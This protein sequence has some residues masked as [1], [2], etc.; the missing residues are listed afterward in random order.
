MIN[1]K[2]FLLLPIV[3]LLAASVKLY[4]QDKIKT[5]TFTFVFEGK[6]LSGLVD[7]PVAKAPTALIILVSGS[8]K[9]N[10][11]AG[12]G[13]YSLRKLFIQQGLACLI[14][15]KAGCGKSEGVFDNNQS[16]QNSA[17]EVLS[18]I[19]ESNNRN[20]PGSGNIGLWGIS[21]AGWICPLVIAQ[22]PSIAFWISVSGTDDKESFGYLLE[23]NLLIEGRSEAQTK[24]LV[25]EWKHGINVSKN[26]GTFE[27]NLKATQNLR[28]DPFY[29]FLNGPN[30]P[31]EEGYL[32]WQK[33][34]QT[35]E[36]VMDEQSGLLIYVPDFEKILNKVRC[37]VLAVFGEKDSQVDWRKTVLLYDKTLK[38]NLNTHLT[39][40]I[41]PDGNH[42]MITCKTGG[43]REK[44]EVWHPCEG[45]YETMASWLN[46]NR[47]GKNN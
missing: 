39:I 42:N 28:K 29:I 31:T 34:F 32:R 15:D 22:Y 10:I 18:A 11:V 21:R 19:E 14:W 27:D 6:K 3:F 12:N 2:T 41:F 36:N 47:F 4:S 17:S 33:K 25:D 13:F 37:P 35:G 38:Q 44:I 20:I 26:G 8:G 9:T 7:L 45:Y 1:L 23:K 40:K 43:L 46:E 16:V 24:D 30:S 5:D